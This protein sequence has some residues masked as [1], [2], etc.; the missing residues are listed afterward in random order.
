MMKNYTI[1]NL[2]TWQETLRVIEMCGIIQELDDEVARY[3]FPAGSSGPLY[4]PKLNQKTKYRRV[5]VPP[6]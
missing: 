5:P 2:A 1:S 6:S 4:K 3:E